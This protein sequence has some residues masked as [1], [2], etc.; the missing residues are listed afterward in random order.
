MGSLAASGGYWISAT[1]DQIWALPTTLTGSIGIFGFLPTFERTLA[2]YGVYSDGVGTTPLSNVASIERGLT[3]VYAEI[4]Q[5]TIES[6]YRQFLETVARGRNM[7]TQ[8]RVW[9]GEKALEL[10]LV[11]KLGDLEEAIVAASEIAGVENYSVW[12]VEPEVSNRD[13]LITTLMSEVAM[14]QITKTTNPL[15]MLY[16]KLERDF[17]FLTQ[18]NDPRGAYVICGSCP[19]AP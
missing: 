3:P 15:S 17:N 19:M 11:D 12:Y 8:G 2:R 1:A 6:G 14:T 9:S 13:R 18:L 4:L 16:R 10:G 5:A 7:T